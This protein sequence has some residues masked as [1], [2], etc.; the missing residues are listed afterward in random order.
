MN[1]ELRSS[2]DRC[3]KAL[4][5][6]GRLADELRQEQDHGMQVEKLRKNLESQ[7]KELQVRL[8]EAEAQA[9]K[10]GKKLIQKLEQRVRQRLGCMFG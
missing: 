9:L 1:T 4:G 6:A 8:D 2:E 7:V 10:G 3:K 5:D